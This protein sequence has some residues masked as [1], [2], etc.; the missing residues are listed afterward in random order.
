MKMMSLLGWMTWMTT[1]LRRQHAETP[2]MYMT[3]LPIHLVEKMPARES[4]RMT[5]LLQR[6]LMLVPSSFDD[7]ELKRI[8]GDARWLNGLALLAVIG[9]LTGDGP[10]VIWWPEIPVMLSVRRE[11]KEA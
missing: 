8:S 10:F 1:K 2:G 9:S 6:S 7:R 4:H 11:K 5:A 3:C